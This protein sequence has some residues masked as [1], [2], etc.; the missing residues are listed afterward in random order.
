MNEQRSVDLAEDVL[1]SDHLLGP[2]HAPVTVVEYADFECPNCRQAAPAVRL[3]LEKYPQSVRVVFRHFPL[4]Q[5]HSH[6]LAA[7]EAAECAGVQGKFWQMHDQL[8]EHQDHLH[9]RQLRHYAGELQLDLARFDAQMHEHAHLPR[10]RAHM[11][12]GRRSG[13]RGTPGFFVNGRIRDVSFGLRALF[14]AV[15][16]ELRSRAPP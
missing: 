9:M 5:A 8:F 10:I 16:T 14:D 4:E 13:L 2:G 12:S 11:D 3:L 7:A 6:A 1:P 15:D